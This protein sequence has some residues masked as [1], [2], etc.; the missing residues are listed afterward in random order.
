MPDRA[1]APTRSRTFTVHFKEEVDAQ[2]AATVLGAAH[3]D[4]V[5]IGA[6]DDETEAVMRTVQ[7]RRASVAQQR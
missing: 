5:A 4:V 1:I 3:P 2:W 7:A 6:V